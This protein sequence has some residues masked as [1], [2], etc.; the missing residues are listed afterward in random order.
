VKQKDGDMFTESLCTYHE[1]CLEGKVTNASIS[2]R[3]GVERKRLQ[4]IPDSDPVWD[5]IGYYLGQFCEQLFLSYS[6]EVIIWG[7]GI[8]N[9]KIL[10]EK[11]QKYMLENAAAYPMN[12]SSK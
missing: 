6:P 9:R 1:N 4:D 11:I 2:K 7:G 10:Y 5:A 3:M 8:M 12:F